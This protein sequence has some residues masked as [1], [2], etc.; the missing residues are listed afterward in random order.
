MWRRKKKDDKKTKAFYDRATT[1]IP[2]IS[3]KVNGVWILTGI[4]PMTPIFKKKKKVFF[5]FY[6]LLFH[7]QQLISNYP[8]CLLYNSFDASSENLVLDQLIS[9]NWFFWFILITCQL[10]IVVILW[11]EII[12]WSLVGVKGLTI[13]RSNSN[14]TLFLPDGKYKYEK[15]RKHHPK[16]W[17]WGKSK[18]S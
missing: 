15:N 2:V 3:F 17:Q 6:V 4:W 14:C 5:P 8:Y 18:S 9:P 10:N 13:D 16:I 11:G 7:S 12:S 1:G